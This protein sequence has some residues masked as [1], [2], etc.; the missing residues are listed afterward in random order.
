MALQHTKLSLALGSPDKACVIK[1]WAE[2][3]RLKVAQG[4]S[5]P[6]RWW[7]KTLPNALT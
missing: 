6:N 7:D 3:E 2:F 5:E 4:D 1:L